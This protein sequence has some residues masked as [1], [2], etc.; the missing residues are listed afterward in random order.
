MLMKSPHTALTRAV[1]IQR[2]TSMPNDFYGLPLHP[3]IVHATVVIIPLAALRRDP[4]RSMAPLPSVGRPH[5]GCAQPGRIDPRPAV[6]IN[7]RDPRGA[8]RALSPAE[9]AHPDRRG[10]S[11]LDDRPVRLRCHRLRDPPS[12]QPRTFCRQAPDATTV[13]VLAIAAALGA[14]VQ[15]ARIGHSGAKAA[16]QDTDMSSTGRSGG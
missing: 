16:W 14:T 8:R 1:P 6:Y 12:R 11:A 5:A 7:R 9:E 10:T 3:L 4:Q 13:A 15:V 2:T